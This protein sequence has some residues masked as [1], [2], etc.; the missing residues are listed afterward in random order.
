MK[1]DTKKIFS[2][3]ALLIQ[4]MAGLLTRMPD[5][6]GVQILHGPQELGTDLIFSIRGGFGETVLCGCIVKNSR[7]MGDITKP[8]VART[9]FFQIQQTFDSAYTDGIGKD[10]HLERIYLVT[11]FDISPQTIRAIRGRHQE[12]AGQIVFISGAGLF[13]LFEKFWPDFFDDDDDKSQVKEYSDQLRRVDENIASTVDV[14]V[15]YSDP[16]KHEARIIFDKLERE[17]L[18]VFLAE[19]SIQAGEIWEEK[20]KE[21]LKACRSFWILITP[22][23]LRSEW[24]ITEW[25][26]AWA[27]DK[28]IVPILLRCKPED[29][30]KRL[31]A[32][33][34]IDFHNIDHAISTIVRN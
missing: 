24:V 29:L 8:G 33:H 31:Q 25:A 28:K 16:D 6:T 4:A 2:S 17:R 21:A 13:D 32:Y 27:L 19:K 1:K 12:H 18:K 10:A 23:S 34:C 22:N 3:E 15:S 7:I 9:T 11:P 14:F 26:A 20:I 5:I 30:P